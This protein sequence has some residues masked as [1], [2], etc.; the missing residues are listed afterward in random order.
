MRHSKDD[1]DWSNPEDRTRFADMWADG[2]PTSVIAAAFGVSKN[3]V[4]STRARLGLPARPSPL[5]RSHAALTIDFDRVHSLRLN[6]ASWPAVA[7]EVN[8]PAK[9]LSQWYYDQC[10]KHGVIP[11]LHQHPVKVRE[12]VRHKTERP[13]KAVAAPKP[14]PAKPA[15]VRKQWLPTRHSEFSF[16]KNTPVS[17][18]DLPA[19]IPGGVLYEFLPRGCCHWMLNDKWPWRACGLPVTRRVYCTA[20]TIEADFKRQAEKRRRM[21]MA[22]EVAA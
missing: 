19:P 20:H 16:F 18:A 15:Q 14:A 2:E 12:R 8:H 17:A 21:V 10:A 11:A 9:L 1:R 5:G 3:A 7:I 13:V 6:G 4:V 22:G